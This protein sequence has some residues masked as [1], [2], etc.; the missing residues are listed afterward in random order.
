MRSPIAIL[1]GLVSFLSPCCLPL[2]PGYLAYVTG[3]TAAELEHQ[4]TT[5][6]GSGRADAVATGSRV[7][8]RRTPRLTTVLGTMLFFM[9]FALVFTSYGAAFGAL[10][11][12]L[13]IHWDTITRILGAFT[14][15]LGLFFAGLFDPIPIAG[16]GAVL[17]F[18][19][20]LGLGIPFTL[21]AIGMRRAFT[22]FSFARRHT[23][24]VMR[25]GG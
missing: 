12:T 13:L 10:G 4:Q 23:R 15:L 21:A 18:A 9:G 1:A 22:L 17:S 14:I 8:V 16:R 6:Q 19:Y 20:S 11:A 7:A 3:G 5:S 25:L 24:V 2:L